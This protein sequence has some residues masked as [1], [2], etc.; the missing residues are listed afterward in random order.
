MDRYIQALVRE[1]FSGIKKIKQT[2]F[3]VA[4]ERS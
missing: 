4:G 3:E 1:R 2:V